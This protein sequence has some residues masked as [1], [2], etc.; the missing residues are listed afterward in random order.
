M[1]RP[2]SPLPPKT[3]LATSLNSNFYEDRFVETGDKGLARF[4]LYLSASVKRSLT[5]TYRGMISDD[6][7]PAMLGCCCRNDTDIIL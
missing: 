3:L 7:S 4:R 2:F 1:S 5:K 6:R